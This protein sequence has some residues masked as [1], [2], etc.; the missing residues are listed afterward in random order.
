M[1]RIETNTIPVHDFPTDGLGTFI[2]VIHTD[3]AQFDGFVHV[4][5]ELDDHPYNLMLVMSGSEMDALTLTVPEIIELLK[6]DDPTDHTPSPNAAAFQTLAFHACE[7]GEVDLDGHYKAELEAEFAWDAILEDAKSNAEDG[8]GRHHL[9]TCI[10]LRPSGKF[11]TPWTTNQTDVDVL[12]DSAWNNALE[13]IAEEHDGWI[14]GGE[15]DPCDILFA[16]PVEEQA[17]A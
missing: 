11:H 14:E 7:A 8:V 1:L 15:G 4:V 16:I 3:A 17:A 9:G 2:G 10:A 6:A 5:E 12:L 13:M